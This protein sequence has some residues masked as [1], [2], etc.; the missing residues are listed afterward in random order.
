[1]CEK[2]RERE[3]EKESVSERVSERERAGRGHLVVRRA[4]RALAFPAAVVLPINTPG[5]GTVAVAVGV[6]AQPLVGR[7][8]AVAAVVLFLQAQVREQGQQGRV[9]PAG[10]LVVAR[11]LRGGEREGEGE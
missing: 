10:Q 7:G 8:A 1:M 5:T 6:G 4:P 9:P 11:L 3:C 2:E